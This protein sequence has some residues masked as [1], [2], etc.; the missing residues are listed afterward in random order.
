MPQRALR[1]GIAT[2]HRS[3]LLAPQRRHH[4]RDCARQVSHDKLSLNAYDT[5]AGF[6]QLVVPARVGVLS[7]GVVSA[8][9]L[10]HEAVGRREEIHDKAEQRHLAPEPRA[11][12][13]RAK[14]RPQPSLR[15]GGCLAMV[16]S[17]SGE[18]DFFLGHE[19]APFPGWRPDEAPLAQEL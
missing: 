12:R 13:A 17:V 8:I 4:P 15:I 5:V 14:H 2:A 19:G 18:S 16:V 1:R 9:D 7:L 3:P 10:D 11:L 6:L